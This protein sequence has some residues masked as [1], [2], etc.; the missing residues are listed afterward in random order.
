MTFLFLK[1]LHDT[2]EEN[3][4]KIIQEGK[5]RK[6]AYTNKVKNIRFVIELMKDQKLF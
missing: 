5:S 2:F 4:E 1:R 3:E 6:D